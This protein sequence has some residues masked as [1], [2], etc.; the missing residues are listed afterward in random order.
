MIRVLIQ[1]FG[2]R[3]QEVFALNRFEIKYWYFT[4][5][6]TEDE[7]R[8]RDEARRTAE[9]N[10][11]NRP[12]VTAGNEAEAYFLDM[13]YTYNMHPRHIQKLWREIL[14]RRGHHEGEHSGLPVL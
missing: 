5:P 9:D 4:P 12:Q 10:W 1:R 8:A 2:L 6:P 11:A 3:K 13:L 7:A 14:A